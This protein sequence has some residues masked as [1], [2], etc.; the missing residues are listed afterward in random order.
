[1]EIIRLGQSF[2]IDWDVNM[3]HEET[4]TPAVARTTTLNEELGQID[5]VFSDKV[6]P[7]T[8]DKETF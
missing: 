8:Y 5:Y 3:F 7:N 1:M 4:N 6:R 2:L